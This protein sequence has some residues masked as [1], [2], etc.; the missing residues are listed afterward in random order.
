M[1]PRKVQ[2]SGVARNS[3]A[4][5]T[6]VMVRPTEEAAGTRAAVLLGMTPAVR[7]HCLGPAANVPVQAGEDAFQMRLPVA[8]C[9]PAGW[10]RP[11]GVRAVRWCGPSRDAAAP[12]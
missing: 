9:A 10:R 6:S 12:D 4:A 5:R 8:S 2:G 7:E 3:R 1:V 11:S